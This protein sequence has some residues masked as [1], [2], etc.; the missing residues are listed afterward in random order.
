[1]KIWSIIFG[2][3]AVAAMSAAAWYDAD[4]RN[5]EE[6]RAMGAVAGYDIPPEDDYQDDELYAGDE[7]YNEERYYERKYQE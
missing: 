7:I 1:M 3:C 2:I 6:D 5:V 4:P